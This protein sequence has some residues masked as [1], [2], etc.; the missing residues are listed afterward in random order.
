MVPWLVGVSLASC[1]PYVATY[2]CTEAGVPVN[3]SVIL[4]RMYDVGARLYSVD[5]HTAVQ[6]RFRLYDRIDILLS[7]LLFTVFPISSRASRCRC[8]TCT[9]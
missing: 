2:S 1:L 7:V 9:R 8:S 5:L 3:T 4:V 6:A